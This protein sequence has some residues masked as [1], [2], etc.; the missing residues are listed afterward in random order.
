MQFSEALLSSDLQGLQTAISKLLGLS[1]NMIISGII[2]QVSE[3]L[4]PSQ[5]AVTWDATQERLHIT[6][7]TA[8]FPDGSA[9][10]LSGDITDLQWPDNDK[11]FL[12]LTIESISATTTNKFNRTVELERYPTSYVELMTSV[13]YDARNVEHSIL[14]AVLTKSDT[15]RDIDQTALY[16]SQ[17]R[18]NAAI[19]DVEH[20]AAK[21]KY[22]NAANAHGISIDDLSVNGVTLLAQLFPTGYVV[23][24]ESDYGIPGRRT[25]YQLDYEI[26]IDPIGR[27]VAPGRYYAILPAIPTAKP[28]VQATDTGYEVAADWVDGT[29][30]MDFGFSHPGPVTVTL[31][32]SNDLEIVPKRMFSAVIDF[33]AVTEGPVIAGGRVVE[34]EAQ[35]CDLG[36]FAGLSLD[37]A[38]EVDSTGVLKTAPQLIEVASLADT[39]AMTVDATS[40]DVYSQIALGVVNSPMKKQIRNP[41]GSIMILDKNFIG[42]RRLIY[43]L[44]STGDEAILMLQ[45]HW[46]GA[47]YALV[48]SEWD[49]IVRRNGQILGSH[50]WRRHDNFVFIDARAVRDGDVF[51]YVVDPFESGRNSKGYIEV[52][53]T[54]AVP[55]GMAATAS[56]DLLSN[57]LD[58]SDEITVSFGS[59]TNYVSLAAGVDFNV[60]QTTENTAFSLAVALNNNPLFQRRAIASSVAERVSITVNKLGV[61]GN[62]YSLSATSVASNKFDVTNFAGGSA[63]YAESE[64]DAVNMYFK[65]N[66]PQGTLPNG[67]KLRMYMTKSIRNDSDAKQ[68]FL[69]EERDVMDGPDHYCKIS[70]AII[71]NM[72]TDPGY[73]E[74]KAFYVKLQIAGIDA[75]GAQ[76]TESIELNDLSCYEPANPEKE[77]SSFAFTS[78]AWRKLTRWVVLDSKNVGNTRLAIMAG[79]RNRG[80]ARCKIANVEHNGTVSAIT[81]ARMLKPS[82]LNRGPV[83][84]QAGLIGGLALRNFQ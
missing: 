83:D 21:G 47:Y 1:G 55:S 48:Q 66:Q 70:T 49:G 28:L 16:Y 43:T 33:R 76:A 75:T 17:N 4:E 44:A 73:D 10:T 40:L 63:T 71:D 32:H 38:V 27:F 80:S 35:S 22:T 84:Q 60:G 26:S 61:E 23:P 15:Q 78:R 31:T 3:T 30:L 58:A 72:S 5:L 9:A 45:A 67:T 74:D 64:Y 34:P 19:A 50:Y 13:E 25:A 6:T 11:L 82:T 62:T 68:Y 51:T 8:L 77:R 42:T 2:S 41:S 39:S 81:D 79:A 59:A 12:V 29:T 65:I 54:G 20:R 36:K 69:I 52:I 7:G 18:P 14:L 46:A 57:A 53:G 24:S 37:I 56:I